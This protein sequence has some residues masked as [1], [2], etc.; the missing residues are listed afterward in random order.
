MKVGANVVRDGV[1][2]GKAAPHDEHE[3][4][5]ADAATE[6]LDEPT[7]Q[8]EADR[9]REWPEPIGLE[10]R[11]GPEGRQGEERDHEHDGR[12]PAEQPGTARRVRGSS[13]VERE[14][15]CFQSRDGGTL[16]G[17]RRSI[18]ASSRY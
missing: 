15:C 16:C 11:S 5:D 17:E 4:P 1:G 18:S 7:R 13:G 8:H 12:R 6:R 14:S 2:A 10:A 9:L 3:Q